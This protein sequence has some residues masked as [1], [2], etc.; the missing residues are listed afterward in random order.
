MKRVVGGVQLLGSVQPD[1]PDRAVLLDV[2]LG[3]EFVGHEAGN[4]R[5]RAATRLRWICDVPPMTLWARL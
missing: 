1:H 2:H 4:P 5:I 3:G